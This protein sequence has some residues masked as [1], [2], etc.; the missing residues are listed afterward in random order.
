[1]IKPALNDPPAPETAGVRPYEMEGR[2]ED[3]TP[4][5]GFEDLAG[6][7]VEC[8]DGADAD[9]VRSREQQMWG[10][11]VGK[12]VHKGT[13]AESR[14]ILR[15]A[16]PIP[17]EGEFDCINMWIHSNSWEWAPEAGTPFLNVS[18]L[19]RDAAGEEQAVHLVRTRWKEWW[20]AHKRLDP[21]GLKQAPLSFSGIEVRGMSNSEPRTIYLDSIY[22]YREA[23]KPLTFDPR[24]K[25]NLT[26]FEGQPQ[27]LNTG[28][29]T[30]PFPTREETILPSNFESDY[31]NEVRETAHDVFEFSYI[32]KDCR[33]KYVWAPK[34]GTLDDITAYV[35]DAKVSRPM[36]GGGVML[37]GGVPKGAA[38]RAGAGK[39]EA[40]AHFSLIHEGVW[41]LDVVYRMRIR[42]KSL[43]IDVISGRTE[44][45]SLGEVR[46]VE[47]PRLVAIPY[48]TVGSGG[49]PKVL[50]SGKPESPVFTSVWIDW[51]R[52]N[53]SNMVSQE[54]AQTDSAKINGGVTYGR[55]TDG[56]VNDLYE[57]VFLTVS[58]TFEETLPT[59]ANPV[60]E[61]AHM[62]VDRLWQE[63][64][65]P[66][67]F[68]KEHERSRMLRSY[69][70]DKLIQCNHEISWRDGGE[71]FTLRTK[72]APGKGGD[73]ALKAYVAAQKS[74]GW[75]SGLY[76]NYTD[77]APVNEYWDE[78]HVQRM[79]DGEWRAAWPRCYALKP[80]RAVEW[81][82]KLAP[83]IKRKFD[84]TSA[85]TDVH[86]AVAPWNYCDFD[87]R[88]PGAGT[89]AAT[90]YAYGE[91]LLNDKKVYGGPI[92]SEGTYQWIYAGLADGN[93]ALCY[94]GPDTSVE[95]L[96]VAFDLHKIHPLECDIGMPWTG[97]FLKSAGWNAPGK[98]DA[99]IDHFIAA[100]MAYGHIGW[101]VEEGHGI[102][103]TCRSYYMLQQL[104]ARYGLR[105]PTTI[106]Y[107]DAQGKWLTASQAIATDVIRE[108]RLHVAYEGGLDLYVNGSEGNW[109]VKGH[110]LPPWGW[111]A[112]DGKDF[113]EYSALVDGRRIDWVKSPAYEYLDGRGASVTHGGLSAKGSI[114]VRRA[115]DSVEVIDIY[116]NDWIGVK[117]KG[118]G[119]CSAIDPD[120]KALGEAE[121]RFTSD[122]MAW[123]RPVKDARRYVIE[124]GGGSS[125]SAL[126]IRFDRERVVPGDRL[127]AAISFTAP[128]GGRITGAEVS[129]DYNPSQKIGDWRDRQL[130]RGVTRATMLRLSFARDIRPGE[131]IWIKACV[132]FDSGGGPERFESWS[133]LTTVP[134]FDVGLR[135]EGGGRFTIGLT[136]NLGGAHKP[137]IGL[138]MKDASSGFSIA[139]R[140]ET[141]DGVEFTVRPPAELRAAEGTLVV[142]ADAAGFRTAREF[143]VRAFVDYPS[144]WTADATTRFL[145]GIAFRGKPEVRG[146]GGT[147]ASF[148]WQ[149]ITSGGVTK[150][151]I[152]SHPPYQGGVGYT[153][154]IT[155]PI[156]IPEEPC[157]FRCF[158]GIKDGGDAS[159]G[160]T[161][162]VIALD[163]SNAERVLLDESWAERKW[164]G[165]SADLSAFGGKSIRL[166]FIAD[167][168]P[169]DNSSAD[170]A[171]W[172]E[173]RI[174]TRQP[175]MR[176]EVGKE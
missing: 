83:I 24:P 144:V 16:K 143:P 120:G 141:G 31:R 36:V 17:I 9:L 98:I 174:T 61:N 131:R 59:I 122:G 135:A 138:R 34:T 14:A 158:I 93:Y 113:E 87:A 54:W 125:R 119:T 20:L 103:R 77:Y 136:N 176:V 38:V 91:L 12:L 82:A 152:F 133:V 10:R 30:L 139:D 161:F 84:S 37:G 127:D 28:P 39:D 21:K 151:G 92:F 149:G 117:V 164:K 23:L 44:G 74:L 33:V 78:D 142:T 137:R 106:E 105:R 68:E 51:Y 3:R 25:R 5:F 129:Y 155:E 96:N 95:P 65:G 162:K 50:C 171:S 71:S 85:Y 27:G 64:W 29:G 7:T 55:K 167:V 116:G 70:I 8:I 73:P 81:E 126:S 115:E 112:S 19:L 124:T 42:G 66:Q 148:A 157:E 100:T 40:E 69:G 140:S 146:T 52:S 101:L 67:D 79:S 94:G 159:D 175:L 49:N 145:T 153:Y 18:I 4:L 76:T 108:S 80:S 1:M 46:D 160:V 86:T 172:G 22:F 156:V 99:S 58:P 63:S 15:P 163:E 26:P 102:E 170:W 154:G 109:T 114:A 13:S 35:N 97:G 43:V 147:G 121:V 6:W 165:V 89:F 53:A 57:R 173:P 41:A 90:F 75:L 107:A 11:Y 48:I 2:T 72:A 150:D 104:Q 45:L 60:G 134:A 123:I 118:R 130:G 169:N 166:K 56:T 111:Y 110:V 62:A 32:G 168:G 88:V 128:S 47:N 132:D